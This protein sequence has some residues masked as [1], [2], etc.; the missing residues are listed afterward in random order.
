MP[1]FSVSF[2]LG[3]KIRCQF[4]LQL[5]KFSVYFVFSRQN[6]ASVLISIGKIQRQF[7]FQSA[8]FSFNFDFNQKKIGPTVVSWCRAQFQSVSMLLVPLCSP[9]LSY[10][11]VSHVKTR[12]EAK[13]V[14]TYIFHNGTVA[15][16][17]KK[18]ANFFLHN[19]ISISIWLFY[20]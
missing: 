2:V 1:K 18:R 8:K 17:P 12:S 10:T 15:R 20:K 13:M 9:W 6:S 19:S 3:G 11:L 4:Q 7:R 14:M 5:E 16:F